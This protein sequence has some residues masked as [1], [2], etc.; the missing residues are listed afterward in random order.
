MAV[1]LLCVGDVHLGR[2]PGGL[3]PE[4]LAELGLQA[5][6][7]GPRAAW[8]RTVAL[9]LA[10]RVDAVLLAG[11]VVDAERDYFESY[12]LL[13]AG[14][15]RLAAAEIRVLGVVGNHD[16]VVLPLLARNLASFEL[17][18]K[19][20]VWQAT[21]VE[22]RRG[23]ALE[24]VGWSFPQR[25]VKENPLATLPTEL[26]GR[27]D[28]PRI[29]LLHADLDVRSSV[30]APVF[31]SEL[32]ATGLDAWLLGHVHK[33]S[34]LAGP[35]PIGYLGSLSA[36]RASEVGDRG[37]WLLEA[38]AGRVRLEQRVLA[39]L[40]FEELSI[41]VSAVEGRGAAQECIQMAFERRTA[42]L[43]RS[44]FGRPDALLVGL[45]L[46]LVGRTHD[47]QA[48][49]AATEDALKS[50]AVS[51]RRGEPA[52]FIEGI[53]VAARNALDLETSARRTDPLGL[54]AQQLLVLERA[55]DDPE[56]RA[57]I[58][59]ARPALERRRQAVIGSALDA[60]DLDDEALAAKLRGA[61]ELLLDEL[62]RQER[63]REGAA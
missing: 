15:E 9:A 57:L 61:G 11:D 35:R 6:A 46:T 1:R 55:A 47:R 51:A 27:G 19:D 10:E 44:E 17:L 14:I 21:R 59:A 25:Q 30:Y 3:S 2:S 13:S 38:D 37:P 22:G 54:V 16:V 63:G 36:L 42:E 23:E 41:D 29:G 48:L 32:G 5:R 34:D 50:A 12:A 62:L 7:L 56:R 58:T 28:V 52:V 26:R 39:P 18:G 60:P 8:E 45:R 49:F 31:S 4:L 20:G 53:E 43:Q 33:P 40:R 24:V